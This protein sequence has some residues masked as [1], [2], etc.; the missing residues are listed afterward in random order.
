MPS[1]NTVTPKN[2]SMTVNF[3]VR[4]P[5]APRAAPIERIRTAATDSMPPGRFSTIR[6][7]SSTSTRLIGVRRLIAPRVCSWSP[8][9]S[10]G[11]PE[12][13][14]VT[15]EP[16]SALSTA[17]SSSKNVLWPTSSASGSVAILISTR[18]APG[19]LATS[20]RSA[21]AEA[22]NSAAFARS[23]GRSARASQRSNRVRSTS[24]GACSSS[25]SRGRG[26]RAAATDGMARAARIELST[27]SSSSSSSP[28]SSTSSSPPSS[29]CSD[30]SKYRPTCSLSRFITPVNVRSTGVAGSSAAR[31][32]AGTT[33]QAIALHGDRIVQRATASRARRKLT[34]KAPGNDPNRATNDCYSPARQRPK[35]PQ[36]EEGEEKK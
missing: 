14:A 20:P 31:A 27:A 13:P 5:T 16:A 10:A 22:A 6:K 33:A 9:D 4:R 17:A 24:H 30:I 25:Q 34:G 18:R 21:N 1:P 28:S 29:Y 7:R 19:T 3:S 11:R 36:R 8:A 32:S 2:V 23:P 35:N 12:K 15:P 26:R